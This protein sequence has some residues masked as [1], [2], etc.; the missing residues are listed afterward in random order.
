M[1]K[2]YF[3]ALWFLVACIVAVP[4]SRAAYVA[5]KSFLKPRCVVEIGRPP[6]AVNE[7]DDSAVFQRAIDA[8]ARKGGGH[9]VVPTGEYQLMALRMKS[10]VHLLFR[11]GVVVHPFG[12]QGTIFSFGGEGL[13]ENASLVGADDPV[14]FD[15]RLDENPRLRLAKVG[16]CHNFRLANLKVADQ[17][18]TYSSLIFVSDGERDGQ[19]MSPCQGLVENITVKNAHH[20][21]GAI[22]AHTAFDVL[23]RNIDAEGGAAVRLETGLIKLNKGRIAILD[24]IRV[25][26]AIS[27]RGQAALMLAP[28]TL[29]HGKVVAHDI[30]AYGSEMALSIGNGFVSNK[31]YGKDSGLTPGSFES[32]YVDGV[33]A[34]YTPGPIPTKYT[35]LKYYPKE[36][37][38]LIKRGA[39]NEV[40]YTGPSICAV[41][42]M[43]PAE[44]D[45]IIEHVAASGF[46]YHPAIIHESD[47][48]R[49]S[50][51]HLTGK[52]QKK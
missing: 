20:G 15:F 2:T 12:G 42:N 32:V 19:P 46:K 43:T 7:Q 45:V 14:L 4:A 30:R 13:V 34:E 18:S 31:K 51:N 25:E 33:T 38:A 1:Y 16:D 40:G 48:Y 36:L 27:R 9:V 29:N 37:H 6:Y 23:F 49:G 8:V 41:S 26:T 10:E 35:H 22:Q 44:R 17:R 5:P 3:S 24:D 39:D 11:Q 52:G 21:Y 28:H 47:L 50:L